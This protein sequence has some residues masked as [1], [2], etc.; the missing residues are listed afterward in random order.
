ML[1]VETDSFDSCIVFTPASDS[2]HHF[3]GEKKKTIIVTSSG[4]EIIVRRD[5]ESTDFLLMCLVSKHLLVGTIVLNA[6]ITVFASCDNKV[7]SATD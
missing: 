2:I 5:S 4:N 1:R 3:Q 7:V 6:D